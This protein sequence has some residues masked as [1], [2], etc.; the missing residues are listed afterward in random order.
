MTTLWP[1]LP[2]EAWRPTRETLHRY[3]QII[4]KI[5][6]ALTPRI[7]HFWNVTLHL[8]SH[9]LATAAMH[10]GDRT[11]DIE[12]DFIEHRV[13]IRT[14]DGGREML[15][16]RP[17]AVADFSREL[18]AALD[19]LDVHVEI[20]DHPVEI[21]TDAI[22]FSQ[23]RLHASYDREY[24]ARFFRVLSSTHQVLGQF[25]ARFTGKST[26]V[27][28]YWGTFDLSLTHYSG[29]TVANPPSSGFEFER[30]AFSHELFEVGFWP[31]D[32]RYPAPAFY[33]MQWP[34]AEGFPTCGIGPRPA[35]WQPAS[36]CWVLPYE[37]CRDSDV[38]AKLLEFCE[39]AY[40]SSAELAGWNRANL[41]RRELTRAA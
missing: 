30:E 17:L 1:S 35:H 9:G 41:G 3:A 33:A 19:R 4:G 39:T 2:L 32:D 34:M 6:L 10:L 11:V 7:N 8:T 22:P 27:L 16:L 25:R 21:R 29:R 12:L 14:S 26:E 20:W 15:E 28:F 37:D 23:D 13:V 36:S 18:F 40:E 5:Q 31:G 24:A 38:S